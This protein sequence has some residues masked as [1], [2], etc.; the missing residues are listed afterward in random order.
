MSNLSVDLPATVAP[1]EYIY[2]LG[3]GGSGSTLLELLLGGHPQLVAMGE[4]EKLSLQFA[5]QPS[6]PCGCGAAPAECPVWKRVAQAIRDS[7]GV[8]LTRNAFRF[9]VSDVG[10]EEERGFRAP[11]HYLVRHNSRF[12]RYARYRRTP[13]LRYGAALTTGYRRWVQN[14]FFVADDLREQAGAVGV[15]DS[16]KDYLAARDLYEAA[17]QRMKIIFITR[18]VCGSVWSSLKR[19]TSTAREAAVSWRKS[20]QRAVQMLAGIPSDDWTHVP[21]E[22][23]CRDT[24]G[25]CERLCKFLGY[26]YDCRM[27]DPGREP[28]HTI[29]GNKIRLSAISGVREDLSWREHLSPSD[30]QLIDSLTLKLAR[31]LGYGPAGDGA[32]WKSELTI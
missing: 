20:N 12:W 6:R 15:I 23:L 10:W 25:T 18:S 8:D 16:S 21:Y 32:T 9:R 7:Y 2:I 27:L 24:K 4:L 22:E 28:P 11:G 14:R 1:A 31:Q 30:L 26:S 19:G 3:H 13:V 17:T 5:R 29:G